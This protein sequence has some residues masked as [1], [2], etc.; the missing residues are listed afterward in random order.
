MQASTCKSLKSKV[1]TCSDALWINFF[2]FKK[3]SPL[4]KLSYIRIHLLQSE[5]EADNQN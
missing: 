2:F 5:R 1:V 4:T 3:K